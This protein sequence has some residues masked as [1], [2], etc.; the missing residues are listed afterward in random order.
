MGEEIIRMK[1]L[2]EN[3]REYLNERLNGYTEPQKT[4]QEFDLGTTFTKISIDDIIN[5]SFMKLS[6]MEQSIVMAFLDSLS[7]LEKEK[8][9]EKVRRI[10]GTIRTMSGNS[11]DFTFRDKEEAIRAYKTPFQYKAHSKDK[12]LTKSL[13]DWHNHLKVIKSTGNPQTRSDAI[14]SFY[15]DS[16]H[17]GKQ[18]T[19]PYGKTSRR[20]MAKTKKG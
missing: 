13:Q 8:D 9:P 6:S 19:D 2:F 4:E 14:D 7:K 10:L 18:K 5:R 15:A 20:P 16:D 1:L 17:Y 11:E 3:W 12:K